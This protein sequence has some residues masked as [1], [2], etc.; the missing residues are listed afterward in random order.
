MLLLVSLKPLPIVVNGVA[1]SLIFVAHDVGPVVF[2]RLTR[3]YFRYR[4]AVFF[5]TISPTV[6]VLSISSRTF[7]SCFWYTL[8]LVF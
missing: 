2:R 6:S 5:V 4:C 3:C 8:L 1:V 7:L